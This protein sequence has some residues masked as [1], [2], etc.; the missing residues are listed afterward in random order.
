MDTELVRVDGNL[1][2]R[3]RT[4]DTGKSALWDDCPKL[5]AIQDPSTA[6]W[7]REEFLTYRAGDWAIAEQG[8]AGT[9]AQADVAGG[10]VLLTTDAL[11][12]DSEEMQK[13]G[14]AYQLVGDKPLWFE[15]K[16]QVSEITQSDFVIGLG[17]T[18]NTFI[19]G[20]DDWVGFWKPDGAA[21]VDWHCIESTNESTGTTSV[22]VVADTDMRFGFKYS[23]K[24]DGSLG[25][26][27]YYL[28]GVLVA[29]CTTNLPDDQLL[30][31]TC[32]YQNGVG[33]AETLLWKG[34]EVFQLR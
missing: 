28:D 30:C 11:D 23:P 34:Y 4:H 15:A 1:F 3:D 17:V 31:V 5:A 9:V 27:T 22:S 18:D 8:A 14:E 19:D 2:F 26:V 10:G 12:N 24:G 21:T 33:G 6:S 32:G 13:A 16:L 25:T 29:T 7:V 20:C